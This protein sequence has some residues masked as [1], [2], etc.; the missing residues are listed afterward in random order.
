MYDI[1]ALHEITFEDL[2][3]MVVGYTSPGRYKVDKVETAEHTR[4]S[5]QRQPLDAPYEKA[6][7]LD[8]EMCAIYRRAAASGFSFAAFDVERMIGLALA[9]A[10]EWNRSLWVWEFH[11][12]VD[13]RRRGVGRRLMARLVE[14]AEQAGLRVLVCET[15]NTNLP[16]IDFYRAVG[17]EMEGIDLSYYTN[18]DATDGEVAVFMKL[19][20]EE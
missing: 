14:Q 7:D 2:Q 6:F 4:I 13:C 3:R 9:E 1:R 10:Q 16:A 11:V 20:L 15:Q 18:R 12:A 17:F 19:K 8:D 5:L